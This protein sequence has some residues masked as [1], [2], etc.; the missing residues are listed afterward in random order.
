MANTILAV[1]NL[2]NNLGHFF[3]SC[4]Q[5]LDDFFANINIVPR[6]LSGNNLNDLSVKLTTAP[7]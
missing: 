1:D 7:F 4:R 5:N 2:D 6:L 3:D